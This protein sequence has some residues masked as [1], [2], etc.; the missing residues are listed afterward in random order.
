MRAIHFITRSEFVT[1]VKNTLAACNKDRVPRLGAALAFYSVLSLAPTVVVALALAGAV[2]GREAAAGQLAW[3]IH[4]LV[5]AQAA[6]AIQTIINDARWPVTGF[7]AGAIAVVSLFLGA[8]AVFHELRDALN[9]IWHVPPP[10][11]GSGWQSVLAE[12]RNRLF[13]FVVVLVVGL[14][15]LASVAVNTS[16]AAAGSYFGWPLS[17][18]PGFVRFAEPLLSFI[19][20]A[21]GFAAL[22][23]ILPNVPIKW[24]DVVVGS[25]VTSALFTVGKFL[26]SL[27]LS[28]ATIASAYGAAGSLVVLLL[29]VYYSAQVF[30]VGAEFTYLYMCNYGSGSRRNPTP[31]APKPDRGQVIQ[32]E[33]VKS[34]KG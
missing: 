8:S 26:I 23:K 32:L 15:V 4:D 3:Q 17:V 5:G 14:L 9:M 24:S 2:F 20:I 19:V 1:L 21:V 31:V 30:F 12:V 16:V 11:H 22:Y 7:T 13:S 10:E 34:Q 33:E 28:R 27:Y 6:R 25:L 18:P 29:W